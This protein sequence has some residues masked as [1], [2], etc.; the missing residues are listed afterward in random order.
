VDIRADPQTSV[1]WDA[2]EGYG[3]QGGSAH[4]KDNSTA[5]SCQIQ[6]QTAPRKQLY[7]KGMF[8]F[9][10]TN[11]RHYVLLGNGDASSLYFLFA[12]SN[13]TWGHYNGAQTHSFTGDGSTYA[14]NRW[15]SVEVLMD[16]NIG[17]YS[18]WVDNRRLGDG[19]EIPGNNATMS[20]FRILPAHS[21][22]TAEMWADNIALYDLSGTLPVHVPADGTGPLISNVK[23]TRS[24]TQYKIEWNTNE[25]ATREVE[26]G[27]SATQT[28][29]SS[30]YPTLSTNHAVSIAT[31]PVATEILIFRVISED[32]SGNYAVSPWMDI[33]V[34]PP[35]VSVSSP[36][37]NAVFTTPQT[38]PV[39]ANATDN[40]GVTKVWFVLND[41]VVSTDTQAPYLYSWAVTA[42]NNGAHSWRA[43]A[44]DAIGNSSTTA[45]VPV[46]VNIDVTPPAVALTTP[47]ANAVFTTPQTVEVKA[48]ATDNV[49]VSKVW[50]ILD[51]VMVSTD[52]VSPYEYGWLITG[53][54]NGAHTWSATAFDAI[55][56]SSTTASVPVTVNIDV[57]PPSVPAGLQ[58]VAIT[59]TSLSLSW[60][61]STDNVGVAGYRIRRGTS[62]LATVESGG[63]SFT[64]NGLSA[65][66][67][68]LYGVLA[69]DAAGNESAVSPDLAVTTARAPLLAPSG[70]VTGVTSRSIAVRWE[71]TANAT[72]YHLAASQSN[73]T[74]APFSLQ[75]ETAGTNDS[76]SGLT[77]NTTYYFFLNA[78]DETDCTA[79]ALAGQALTHATVPT[80]KSVEVM[81]REARLTIDPQGNPAGTLYRI[82]MSRGGGSYAPV[83]NGE[84]VAFVVGGLTPGERY[85]FRV[86]AENHGG[87]KTSFSNVVAAVLAPE[88]VNEARAYP[89]PFRP[90]LGAAAIT[91]DQLPEGTSIRIFTAVGQAVKSLATDATGRADWDLTN[92]EG[93]PVA[94]GVYVAVMEKNGG[95][96]RLKV[97]VQK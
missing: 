13:G 65:N 7:F 57:L 38:V 64:E 94:S 49:G 93:Q 87:V 55:G 68:Y 41:V 72:R 17:R 31:T 84:D 27:V 54:N 39:K 14:A 30:R 86:M 83:A 4:L 26:Y 96:K 1:V 22:S 70:S 48:E 89:V 85:Q 47:T 43:T 90:G 37:L 21:G 2:V 77:P 56:N 18:V 20:G 66:T 59:S 69:F 45:V 53:A 29:R 50:F 24:G 97:V 3:G 62:T 28:S 79:F 19:I 73:N 74:A 92:D 80:L 95:R 52:T 25:P 88:T 8:R 34:T 6:F 36:P 91:F 76:L 32:A 60:S 75:Q 16:F 46:T 42:A 67:F 78:C 35:S 63:T 23:A 9:A 12:D 33:D 61:L 82:E 5:G 44:F 11:K 40:V 51:G 15:Y 58:A 71:M 81:G 10:E